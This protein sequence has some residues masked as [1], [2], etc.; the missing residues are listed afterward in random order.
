MKEI[1]EITLQNYIKFNYQEFD[2]D[3]LRLFNSPIESVSFNHPKDRFPDLFFTLK[4][5]EEIPVEV[6]WKTSSFDHESHADFAWFKENKGLVMVGVI[7]GDVNLGLEQIKVD[8]DKFEKWYVGNSKQLVKDELKALRSL[9]KSKKRRQPK[10]W[11]TLLT[12]KGGALKHFEPALEHETWGIQK[13]YKVSTGKGTRLEEIQKDDLIVF[14]AG[15]H[16]SYKSKT[17][18][19]LVYGR[20]KM[21]EWS[22]KS[23]NGKFDYVC[24]FKV[25]RDY[26]EQY[27]PKIWE[28]SPNGRWKDELFPHRFKFNRNPLMIM[29][30]LN[31]K[32][33]SASSKSELQNTVYVNFRMC[34][35]ETLVDMMHK[36]TQV[37]V[38]EYEDVLK[39]IPKL[40]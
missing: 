8:L 39:E 27:E 36:A 35:P 22:K 18:G 29:K 32:D 17:T 12:K 6:E 15:L 40:Q 23:F 16:G 2:L 5:G 19:K 26:Q 13:N 25:T 21:S 31:V 28:T 34:N 9:E 11:I 24:I 10:L 38:S 4:N 30:D 3:F 7:E 1:P 20:Y 33:L 14:L 37:N